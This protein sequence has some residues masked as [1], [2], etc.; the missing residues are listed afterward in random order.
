M[1]SET[2]DDWRYLVARA[3]RISRDLIDAEDLVQD[4]F[5]RWL[6]TR[7]QPGRPGN[8]RAWMNVVLRN[9]AIDQL[10]SRR[11]APGPI[12]ELPAP[13]EDHGAPWWRDLDPGD[14]A[15]AMAELPS[16][17]RIAY[18]LFEIEAKSYREIA[19]ALGIAPS[20]VGVRVLRARR[21]LRDLLTQRR[22]APASVATHP[23]HEATCREPRAP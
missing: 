17:L 20:T 18:Q 19:A 23:A 15:R 6:R 8:R 4:V 13:V 22:P 21:R 7:G 2:H 1:Q 3:R 11:V 9:L 14:V 5:E 16:A 12:G 10:R